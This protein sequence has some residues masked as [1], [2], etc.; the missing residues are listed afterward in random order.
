MTNKT[1]EQLQ[2]L[3]QQRHQRP[4]LPHRQE[5]H[6]TQAKNSNESTY[7]LLS[8]QNIADTSLQ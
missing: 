5:S 4:R 7:N 6:R 1:Y 3:V 8:Q 2:Q